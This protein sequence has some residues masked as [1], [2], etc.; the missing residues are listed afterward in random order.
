M[1]H[2]GNLKVSVDEVVSVKVVVILT[3]GIEQRFCNLVLIILE[4]KKMYFISFKFVN[5]FSQ[6][7]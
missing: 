1:F 3:K 2:L 5:T 6:P 4:R 7:I